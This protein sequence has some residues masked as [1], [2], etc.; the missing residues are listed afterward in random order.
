MPSL[1]YAQRLEERR[2]EE[3]GEEDRIFYVAL[4]RARDNI[5]VAVN[6]SASTSCVPTDNK[7]NS[8]YSGKTAQVAS[9]VR[10]R[11]FYFQAPTVGT[12]HTFTCTDTAGAPSIAVLAV[13]GSIASPSDQENGATNFGGS[14]S[15][16]TTGSVT[17]S[18]TNQLIVT[19]INTNIDAGTATI[20]SGFAMSDQ[21]ATNPGNS[22][23]I[24]LAYLIET[25]AV[26][27]NPTWSFTTASDIAIAIATF[28][29]H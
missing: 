28:K 12:G 24:S 26:A 23:G 22:W 4:T 27:Q 1:D 29:S 6:E 10:T 16:S 11:F 8:P 17:P 14:F 5:I 18:N 9:S 25:T 3:S 21:L 2:A 20:D 19:A 13:A 15:S 7:G